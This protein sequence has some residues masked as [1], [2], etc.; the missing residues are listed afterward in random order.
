[1]NDR[2]KETFDKIHAEEEL[3]TKTK[4]FIAYK[5]KGYQ[6]YRMRTYRYVAPIMASFVLILF[7]FF[8]Y[9]V[10]FTPVS[11]ISI[12]INPSV[13]LGINRFD[14]VISIHSYNEDGRKL[15]DTMADIKFMNYTDAINEILNGNSILAY[16]NQEE[17]LSISVIGEDEAKSS[18]ML[19]NVKNCTS[20]HQNVYCHMADSEEMA[21]AHAQGMSFG[22]YQAFLELQKVN[23]D[24]TLEEVETLTMRQI[25]DMIQNSSNDVSDTASSNTLVQNEHGCQEGNGDG[26]QHQHGQNAGGRNKK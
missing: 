16:L 23:P 15:A 10:Y 21:E 5:T 11:M 6:S 3:K 19:E 24:I 4:N 9:K 7:A 2:L 12:D 25:W 14:K 8:G 26:N 18:E 22:K 13:E 17:V 20:Q 1:M